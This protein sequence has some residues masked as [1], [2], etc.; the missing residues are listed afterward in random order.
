MI[1]EKFASSNQKHYPDLGSDTSL[2]WNFSSRS[3]DVFFAGKLVV[4][5]RDISAVYS[6]QSPLG[7]PGNPGKYKQKPT[8]IF[9][10]QMSSLLDSFVFVFIWR[11]RE[12][13]MFLVLVDTVLA[14]YP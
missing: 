12:C 14:Q 10:I 9:T 6:G 11:V 5:R 4:R 3:C 8:L 13:S 7:R 1:G 2:V